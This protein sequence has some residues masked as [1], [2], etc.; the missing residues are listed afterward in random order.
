MIDV[1]AGPI[2]M[3]E[4]RIGSLGSRPSGSDERRATYPL[5]QVGMW[6]AISSFVSEEAGWRCCTIYMLLTLS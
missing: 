2:D 3:W 1:C 4:F 6:S 5:L